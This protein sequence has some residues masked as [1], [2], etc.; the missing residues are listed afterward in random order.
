M[1]DDQVDVTAYSQAFEIYG[2]IVAFLYLR[3][4]VPT[5][6]IPERKGQKTPDF[7]CEPQDGKPFHVEVKS[8]DIAGGDAR[9]LAMD[10]GG[11]SVDDTHNVL[12]R[13]CQL[14]NDERASRSWNISADIGEGRQ[15]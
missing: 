8:F 6:R 14:W 2:E 15:G 13:L 7:R 4:R 1:H 11:W 5:E 9:K 3:E 12:H 10:D